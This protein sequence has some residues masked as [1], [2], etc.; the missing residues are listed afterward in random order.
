[1]ALV[2]GMVN[3]LNLTGSFFM[4]EVYDRVIPSRS[5]PTLVALLILALTLFVF[6]G[7]LD[8][9]RGRIL[10]RIGASLDQALCL[11]VY[12]SIIRLPLRMR[13]APH[14][15][16][17]LRD[18]DQLRG[19]LSGTGPSAL[20]DLPWMPIYL[21]ICFLFHPLIGFAATAG[22]ILLISLTWAAEVLTRGKIRIAATMAAQRSS[23]VETCRRNAEVLQAM[24]MAAR[25]ATIFDHLNFGYLK[26]Q[27]GAS[28]VGGSLGA[29]SRASR[30]ALQSVVLGIGAYLVIN[31]K[32]TPGIIIASSILTARAVAPVELAIANWKSFVGTRQSWRRLNELM[33]LFPV[34]AE[35]L[36]L[37]APE[38][39]IAVE[40]CAA[41]PPGGTAPVIRDISFRLAAGQVLGIVGPSASGKSSLARLLVGAWRPAVGKVRIDGASLEQWSATE[42]G[43][44]IGY[45]PQDIELFDGTVTYNI[46]RLEDNPDPA[47]VVAAAKA[48]GIHELVLR[49]SDGYETRIG[50]SGMALSGGQRQRLALARALYGD[51]FLI[52]LDEPYANLDNEGEFALAQA[53][54]AARLRGAIVIMI[55]HRPNIVSEV[56]YILV[57]RDGRMQAFG[58]SEEILKRLKRPLAPAPQRTI[59]SEVG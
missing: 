12:D 18:L 54:K 43:R 23:F 28:D 1:V 45:L 19:F 46:S 17:P 36:A 4:L 51:P 15:Q 7:L 20:F 35:Q 50:E 47:A 33:L 34:Q 41:I 48:A 59:M 21:S 22:G 8:M 5:I 44:Y 2:S 56:D 49:L 24:G 58:P 26:N 31:E 25:A 29:I 52:V 55:D 9:I 39:T 11:R 37:P 53:V 6:L 57:M 30:M 13:A 38:S 27:S 42:L 3:I 16:Q 10:I 32:A 14:D 40:G